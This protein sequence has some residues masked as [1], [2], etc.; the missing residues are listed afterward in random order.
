MLD[1]E[2]RLNAMQSKETLR[3]YFFVTF[4]GRHGLVKENQPRNQHEKT[5]KRL[6]YC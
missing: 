1:P 6:L 3:Q 2:S 5:R 4:I